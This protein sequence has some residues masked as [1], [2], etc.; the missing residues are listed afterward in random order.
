MILSNHQVPV[1]LHPLARAR[2]LLSPSNNNTPRFKNFVHKEHSSVYS[3]SL[4]STS[5]MDFASD[6][7]GQ[8]RAAKFAKVVA[9]I[10]E[11][12]QLQLQGGNTFGIAYRAK[13]IVNMEAARRV[14]ASSSVPNDPA[15]QALEKVYHH[16]PPHCNRLNRRCLV[17]Y[18][19]NEVA[20]STTSE[21][22]VSF[23]CR[24]DSFLNGRPEIL[25]WGKD[26]DSSKDRWLECLK[27]YF[28][29]EETWPMEDLK[30]RL[31]LAGSSHGESLKPECQTC[32]MLQEGIVDFVDPLELGDKLDSLLHVTANPEEG[33]IVNFW[34]LRL[35]Y[36][37][38][39]GK[40][41]HTLTFFAICLCFPSAERIFQVQ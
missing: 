30:N 36:Y 14:P 24:L 29:L 26:C 11:I 4:G 20:S 22:H 3:H 16:I 9:A 40:S 35:E 39:H 34:D 27:S 15:D 18:A 31:R 12:Y 10:L 1:N 8:R 17:C 37:L 23:Q 25:D 5:E 28:E 41:S 21:P 32:A 13:F 7:A 2:H 33:L 19:L 38:L 6:D